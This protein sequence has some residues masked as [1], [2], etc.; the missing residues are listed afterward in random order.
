MLN[1]THTSTINV[2]RNSQTNGI[3]ATQG[4]KRFVGVLFSAFSTW[5]A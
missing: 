3:A 5:A 1:L 4:W 2:I